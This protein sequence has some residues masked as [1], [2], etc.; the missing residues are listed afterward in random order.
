MNNKIFKIEAGVVVALFLV[1]TTSVA[2]SPQSLH[3]MNQAAR[4][5]Y[6]TVTTEYQQTSEFYENAKQD[7][8]TART[9]YRQSKNTEDLTDAL[10]KANLYVVETARRLAGHLERVRAY[11]EGE[12]NLGDR[13]KQ[14]I[15]DRL[16]SFITWLEEKQ[17]VIPAATTRTA[18]TEVAITVRTKW[19]EITRATKR[20]T[21]QLMNAKIWNLIERA[22]AVAAKIERILHRLHERGRDVATVEAWLGDFYEKID[23]AKQ[24]YHAAREKYAE[25]TDLRDADQFI[26]EGKAFLIEAK[27]YLKNAY[28]ILREIV[29]EL[30][31]RGKEITVSG[32]GTLV[33]EGDGEIYIAGSGTV[34]LSGEQGILTVTNSSGNMT[35]TVTGFRDKIEIGTNKWQ[36][37]GT[38]S[39]TVSGADFI[40]ELSGENIHLTAE[41]TGSATFTGTG[42][43]TLYKRLPGERSVYVA[44]SWAEE[45]ATIALSGEGG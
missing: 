31:N 37:N 45:G 7:W 21:G 40:V 3:D 30:K 32:T 19:Q 13:E 42:S 34:E 2:F 16:N 1:T 26:K 17:Q 15:L 11:V 29:K 44:D 27:R 22:E 38:G 4:D 36:Y 12:S 23:V 14:K 28:I 41:G 39:A 9:R 5:R 25:V 20:I 43:Y 8:L 35:I 6:N 18:L 24:K 33:A 10:E